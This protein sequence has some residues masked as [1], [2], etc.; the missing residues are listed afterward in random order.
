MTDPH[1]QDKVEDVYA[2]AKE[3]GAAQIYRDWARTYDAENAA[4]GFRLPYLAAAFAARYI[5]AGSGPILDAG[6]GTGIVGSALRVLGY[7]QITGLDLSPEMLEVAEATGA[8]A[9]LIEARLGGQLPFDDDSFA[10]VL[11]IGSFGPGHAPPDSLVDLVR[12]AR[13]GAPI[14]FNV[15]EATWVEQGFPDELD[16]LESDGAWS[17]LEASDPFRPYAIG[18]QHLWGRLFAYQAAG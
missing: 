15:V 5:P 4:L 18:E 3:K 12:V 11:C 1:P 13:P 10:G 6:C 7:P 14:L 16:R 8:Y 9:D 17:L 2:A